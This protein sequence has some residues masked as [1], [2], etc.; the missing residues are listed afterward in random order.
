MPLN[1]DAA[2]AAI[3]AWI[4]TLTKVE[5]GVERPFNAQE[6]ADV[7]TSLDPLARAL[8]AGIIA[9]AQVAPTGVPTGLYIGA[10][11]VS[12]WGAVT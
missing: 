2:D 12:G 6:R 8:Y 5:D 10:N 11:A 3:D 7:H 4:D 1:N 9:N